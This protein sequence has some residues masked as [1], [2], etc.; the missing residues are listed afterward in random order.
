MESCADVPDCKE[1]GWGILQLAKVAIQY[2]ESL[3]DE[4]FTSAGDNGHSLPNTIWYYA[5]RPSTAPSAVKEESV[6]KPS[7]S[8]EMFALD[9][10]PISV[11]HPVSHQRIKVTRV[12]PAVKSNVSLH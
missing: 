12:H 8:N 1:Q 10:T 5:T 4:A 7:V 9:A 3:A 2:A 6:N 11:Y